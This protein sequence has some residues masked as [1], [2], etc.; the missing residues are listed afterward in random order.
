MLCRYVN[1]KECL[2]LRESEGNN[3]F[4]TVDIA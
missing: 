2:L 3:G 1:R 4:F